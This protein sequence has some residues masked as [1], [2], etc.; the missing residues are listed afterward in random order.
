MARQQLQPL[1]MQSPK[2]ELHPSDRLTLELE[3]LQLLADPLYVHSLA[4]ESKLDNPGFLAYIRYLH[5]TYSQPQYAHLLL[6]P[7]GLSMARALLQNT[8]SIRTE[9][10]KRE[11][12]E[13]MRRSVLSLSGWKEGG[14]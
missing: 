7:L 14:S 5:E 11:V 2:E 10:G 6:Y 9:I 4:A 8:G 12:A 3:F 13:A 1:H